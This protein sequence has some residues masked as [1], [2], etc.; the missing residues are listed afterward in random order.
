ME[1]EITY[2]K[3][4]PTGTI[5]A[6]IEGS[7]M[8]YYIKREVVPLCSKHLTRQVLADCEKIAEEKAILADHLLIEALKQKGHSALI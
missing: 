8:G 7:V 3:H 5:L 6:A 4:E 1:Q 2:Y